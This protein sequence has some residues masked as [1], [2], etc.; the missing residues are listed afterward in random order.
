MRD[1]LSDTRNILNLL[2]EKLA[3]KA[4]SSHSQSTPHDENDSSEEEEDEEN[5]SEDS[6]A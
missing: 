6:N 4:S 1:E 2:M 5:T 3:Y